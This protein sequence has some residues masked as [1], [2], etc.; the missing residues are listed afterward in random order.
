MALTLKDIAAGNRRL[1]TISETTSYK[2]GGVSSSRGMPTSEIQSLINSEKET[3]TT[4]RSL[5][6]SQTKL[7]ANIDKL[8]AVLEKSIKISSLGVGS[9]QLSGAK[10][11]PGSSMTEN[12]LESQRI[13]QNMATNISYLPRIYESMNALG[14][15]IKNLQKAVENMETA[16]DGG[17]FFPWMPDFN[18]KGK[19]PAKKPTKGAAKK[20]AARAAAKGAAKTGLKSFLKKIPLIGA[21]AGLL[22]AADRA[23]RGDTTG[24]GMELAS[25]IASTAPGPGTAASFGIDAALMAKD[26]KSDQTPK[27]ETKKSDQ[28]PKVETK[29][30]EGTISATQSDIQNHPNYKRYLSQYQKNAKTAWSR[31]AAY[32]K[33]KMRVLGDMALEQ[34]GVD[35]SMKTPRVETKKSEG[36]WNKIKAFFGGNKKNDQQNLSDEIDRE[37]ASADTIS[38]EDVKKYGGGFAEGGSLP[39][40]KV[41]MVGE[42]GPELVAGPGTVLTA[43]DFTKQMYEGDAKLRQEFENLKLE[44]Y[45]AEKL[46]SPEG[47]DGTRIGDLS[48]E[49]QKQVMDMLHP[50]QGHLSKI[51]QYQNLFNSDS[52]KEM[53]DPQRIKDLGSN[54]NVVKKIQAAGGDVEKAGLTKEEKDASQRLAD[55]GKAKIEERKL[56]TES[57]D[58]NKFGRRFGRNDIDAADR[59]LTSSSENEM[60]KT[61][62]GKT[63]NINNIVHAPTNVSNT[64]QK[65]IIPPEVRNKD[66][67]V[68]EYY[69]SRFAS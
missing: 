65:T 31:D 53:M 29:K 43:E 16:A 12:E 63:G 46:V 52:Y 5:L 24:A 23:S 33:A 45:A 35:A 27:V 15:S 2:T 13:T 6:N 19:S 64:T 18:P 8:C 50:T 37:Y 17:G 69:R 39:A 3:K 25:G 59:L 62:K 57:L 36:M 4:N 26:M 48:K 1:G 34:N 41:G 22:F 20:G 14:K 55:W 61:G 10:V 67:S 58:P 44:L 66:T 28:T 51:G 30:Y 54:L 21:G 47:L 32:D 49:D 40:G 38:A 7:I 68:N 56:Q 11:T 42:N 9:N 60:A